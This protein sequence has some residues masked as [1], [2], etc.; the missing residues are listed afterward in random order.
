VTNR[1][2]LKP[3]ESKTLTVVLKRFTGDKLDDK[4]FGMNGYPVKAGGLGTIDPSQVNQILFFVNRP[5]A[6]CQF[7]VSN[8][9]ASGAY[10]PPTAWTSDATPFFPFIDTFGQYKHKDWSGKTH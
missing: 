2:T 10:V 6:D 7:E 3:G 5:P 8:L 1:E 9:R 4:L